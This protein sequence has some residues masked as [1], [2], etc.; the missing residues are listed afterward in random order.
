MTKVP[1]LRRYSVASLSECKVNSDCSGEAAVSGRAGAGAQGRRAHLAERVAGPSVANVRRAVVEYNINLG[2]DGGSGRDAGVGLG[3]AAHLLAGQL[4]LQRRAAPRGRNVLHECPDAAN[5]LN[6]V[7]VEADDGAAAGH[8]ARCDL[9]PAGREAVGTPR[10]RR[11][12]GRSTYHPP[13]AAQRSRQTD[14]LERTSY[15]LFSWMSLNAD[16]ARKPCRNTTS[17]TAA[18]WTGA[19]GVTNLLFGQPVVLVAAVLAL[20]ADLAHGGKC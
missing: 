7:Q 5:R 20:M 1:P 2:A 18:A 15:F 11:A 12:P 14:A 8:A 10:P 17:D 6:G 13:G 4:A 9:E 3:H 16:R 19:N